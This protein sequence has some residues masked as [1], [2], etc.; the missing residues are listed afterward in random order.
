MD[1]TVVGT[2]HG[3]LRGDGDMFL[4]HRPDMVTAI[5]P[6]V[7]AGPST[8]PAHRDL[9]ARTHIRVPTG[10]I[11]S[12]RTVPVRWGRVTDV[13]ATAATTAITPPPV[14]TEII[15]IRRR[16]TAGGA[17][18]TAATATR[19]LLRATTAAATTTTHA[20]TQTITA[21]ATATAAAT[22]TVEAT[23][24]ATTA[25]ETTAADAAAATAAEAEAAEV[26]LRTDVVADITRRPFACRGMVALLLRNK[27]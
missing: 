14:A 17:A 21:A 24:A 25:A 20:A 10:I 11:R 8:T 9:A 3:I 27:P 5:A 13:Q 18:V 1:G 7:R 23:E 15:T 22:T 4:R 26:V 16:T 6:D 12:T 2:L 19:L